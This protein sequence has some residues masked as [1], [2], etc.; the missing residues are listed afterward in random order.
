MSL[1]FG[2]LASLNWLWLVAAIAI[3]AWWGLSRRRRAARTFADHP[4]LATIAPR[5]S[6]LR[7]SIRASLAVLGLIALVVALTDPRWGN[8]YVEVE[9][10]GM[11]VVFV[12][13]VSQSMLAGDASPNRLDRSRL[14]IQDAIDAMAGDRIGL[15][16]FAGDATLR[17][18]I[19]LNYDALETSL[20]ELTPKSSTRGGSMLGDAIRTAANAFSDTEPGGK[21][22]VVLSDGEDMDSFPVEAARK[23]WD[24]YGARVYTVGIGDTVD[25]ARI[26]IRMNGQTSWLTYKGQEVWT[27]MNP[28]LLQEVAQ[29]GGG[30]FI[31]AG[32]RLVDLGTFFEDWIT[33]IDMKDREDITT[34]QSTPRF[35]WFAGLALMLL[36]LESLISERRSRPARITP[37]SEAIA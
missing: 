32:T 29:A 22:I 19:T 13:D 12:V 8:R 35:Q 17:S 27:K 10:R 7:P 36:L 4:L 3:L 9:R 21:A 31:P 37:Q 16:D 24:E 1:H 5:L 18:P 34:L 11:D 23:A 25:G 30:E 28:S 6:F 2:H 20:E 15:V 14:F 26:P 33:T